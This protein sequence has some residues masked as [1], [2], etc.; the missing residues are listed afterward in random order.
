ML[1]YS[2]G[3]SLTN[4]TLIHFVLCWF[5]KNC[6]KTTVPAKLDREGYSAVNR[7]TDCSVSQSLLTLHLFE[8]HF[9]VKK[10]ALHDA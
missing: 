8:V 4:L 10:M 5:H 9:L 7:I 3:Y 6:K 2:C 1:Q